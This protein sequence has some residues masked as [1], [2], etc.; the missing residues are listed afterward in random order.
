MGNFDQL[1]EA[2]VEHLRRRLLSRGWSSTEIATLHKRIE[3][4]NFPSLL[5]VLGTGK[6]RSGLLGA[7][8]LGEAAQD[9]AFEAP[10]DENLETGAVRRFL[11][12]VLHE[13][14]SLRDVPVRESEGEE[15]KREIFEQGISALARRGGMSFTGEQ[16]ERVADLLAT[17]EFYRDIASTT[18]A[19]LA[20]AHALPLA[21]AE[22]IRWS[23]RAI[24]VLL[25]LSRD[26]R[27][28]PASA[29]AV[30]AQLRSGKLERP[31]AL[32][33]HTLRVLY[34][35]ATLATISEM[36]RSL[37]AKDNETFRLAVV[38]YARSAGIPIEDAD[39]DVLRESAFNTDDPNL[40]P[41]L[42]VAIER[43]EENLGR[44]FLFGVLE[45]L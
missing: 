5:A 7:E 4:L 23:P 39:L 27:G 3:N 8:L 16:V 34:A 18:A 2:A 38:I 41:I 33:T 32:L 43:L 44:H 6:K 13:N 9:V 12:A 19:T 25:A 11:K 29:W 31:P 22:D 24:R 42:D 40:G 35:T 26:L 20:T 36:I 10:P 15:R 45:R 30:F 21:I 37:L 17:G 1:I 28:T 14:A